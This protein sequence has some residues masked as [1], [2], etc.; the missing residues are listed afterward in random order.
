MVDDGHP[1]RDALQRAARKLDINLRHR[2][3]SAQ[4]L[5]QAIDDY[6]E[7]FRPQQRHQIETQRRAALRAMQAFVDFEPRLTGALINGDGP[8]DRIRLLVTA[9]TPEQVLLQMHEKHLPAQQA[10]VRL[11]LSGGRILNAPAMRF[12]AGD[13]EVEVVILD[14]ERRSDP[15]RD[16]LTGGRLATLS[17]GELQ[18]LLEHDGSRSNA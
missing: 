18:Q 4:A 10:E 3:P 14:A 9:D 8:L 5:Q 13:S 1:L 2:A 16:P 12:I 11:H 7:L 15:P 6:R 17:L